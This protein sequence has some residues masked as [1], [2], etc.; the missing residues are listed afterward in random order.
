MDWLIK[1]WQAIWEEIKARFC[2]RH[3]WLLVPGYESPQGVQVAGYWMCT[4][5]KLRGP[6]STAGWKPNRDWRPS[7]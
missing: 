3:E 4:G 1:E 2:R 5:C 7:C 6:S